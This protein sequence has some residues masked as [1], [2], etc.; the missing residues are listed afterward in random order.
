VSAGREL[1]PLRT[2][3][4]DAALTVELPA[5]DGRTLATSELNRALPPYQGGPFDRLGRGQQMGED[6]TPS[7][8]APLR[9]QTGACRP[10][11]FPS[12]AESGGNDPQRANADPP[13]KRS[14]RPGGFTLHVGSP[15]RCEQ[16][17]DGGRRAT[18]TPLL[19]QPPG[20]RPGPVA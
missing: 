2:S 14:P 4:K 10:A 20:F 6:P 5:R 1:N 18:R 8:P 3:Y 9:L 7:A 15:A 16:A 17:G 11:G 19:S 12:M 13:S